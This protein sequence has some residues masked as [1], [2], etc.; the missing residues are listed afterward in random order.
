MS[1]L[2]L[3]LWNVYLNLSSE[4]KNLYRNYHTK[5]I[6]EFQSSGKTAKKAI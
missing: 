3:L 1:Y 2:T 6:I 4:T 5:V